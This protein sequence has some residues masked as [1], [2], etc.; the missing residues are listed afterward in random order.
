MDVF[1][2]IIL[3][4]EKWKKDKILNHGASVLAELLDN[5]NDGCADDP[6]ALHYLSSPS[7]DL[8]A[9]GKIQVVVFSNFEE[10]FTKATKAALAKKN[11][12]KV[13]TV[14]PFDV[15]T[16]CAGLK[17]SDGCWDATIEEM[18]HFIHKNG[19]GVAYPKIFSSS[20]DTK[21]QLTNAM[22]VAR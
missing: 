8:E 14:T 6:N 20:S 19:H 22:D 1:G 15:F 10:K 4:T 18:C 2:I 17:I 16:K 3:A 11:W 12:V 7:T 21:S 9:L 5:D 13:K